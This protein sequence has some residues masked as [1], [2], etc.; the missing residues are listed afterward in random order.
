[1][2]LL[3]RDHTGSCGIEKNFYRYEKKQLDSVNM[4]L[5]NPY[6][7][8]V[9]SLLPAYITA[10]ALHVEENELRVT[11]HTVDCTEDADCPPW[12]Q[13]SNNR[14]VCREELSR[15]YSVKCNNETLELSVIRC[16]C[17]TFDNETNQMLEGSCIENC[18]NNYHKE[19]MPLPREVLKIN[20]FICEEKW[21]RTG[22]LCGKCLPGHSPLAYS[23]DMRCVKCPEGNRNVWKYLLAA[24]G[25]LTIFYFL[26][27]FLKINATSSY[28]H[29]Y[30]VFSQIISAPAFLRIV[31]TREKNHQQFKLPIQVVVVMYS[32]WNLDF[33]RDLYPEICLNV[34]NLTALALDYAVAIYPLLLTV[35]SYFLIKLHARNIRI[36]VTLWK[37]F[38][39]LF[40]LL[41]RNV[42]S[43]TTII[44]AYTTFFILSYTKFL[45]VSTDL[46][47]PVRARSLNN[48]S[49]TWVLYYDGS[50]DYFGREHLPYA[51]LALVCLFSIVVPTICFLLFYH[52]KCFQRLLTCLKIRSQLLH[53]VMDSFQ[54]SY[55]N[56]IETG[57]KDCRW[58]AAV[59]L[60][61][62]IIL[63]LFYS[64][65][66]D[67]SCVPFAIISIVCI[68]VFTAVIQ[69]YKRHLLKYA[70]LD[71]TFWGFLALF[72]AADE[73]ASHGSLK[74]TLQVKAAN[75]IR[76]A[77][78]TLPLL[79]MICISVHWIL[80][81]MKKMKAFV[82]RLK[83]RRRSYL[84][85][86]SEEET[87]PDR[88]MNP[89]D[90]QERDHEEDRSLS[91]TYMYQND[92]Y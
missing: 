88:L 31:L 55:K 22:R 36:V 21:N 39:C 64:I 92:T 37:P 85:I 6:L 74:P 75:V 10:E 19:Y 26:V 28:L 48:D 70:K 43:K 34:S 62:R 16:H 14:C 56:G 78:G 3:T 38:R 90:Y 69:P 53:A 12:G 13:C 29:G 77:A 49:V 51:M 61:G 73:I 89:Q 30:L 18:E 33:F 7:F 67:S 66:L 46:L 47:I 41:R 83:A 4:K 71:I 1:M 25:P 5:Q 76:F 82:R 20:Q 81:R 23:N 35:V 50:V 27:I 58:F 11:T 24:F 59:P 87:L 79:Y 40:T 45:C 42:D 8:F 54:G 84:K 60:L 57:T 2:Y 32:L 9:T 15:Y 91:N 86:E 80:S 44:D 52:L 63:L 68:I 17:V 72:Y 65:T